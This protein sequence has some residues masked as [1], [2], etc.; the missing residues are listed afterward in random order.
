ME[1][2]GA[3][4]RLDWS[5]NNVGF[6]FAPDADF[7]ATPDRF[8]NFYEI[9]VH[10]PTSTSDLGV[11]EVQVVSANFAQFQP[12]DIIFTTVPYGKW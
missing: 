2:S 4:A 9:Y 5:R 1:S 8:I 11:Y 3:Y 6:S 12:D 7:P 10:D